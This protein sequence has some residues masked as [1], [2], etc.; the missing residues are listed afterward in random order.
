MSTKRMKMVLALMAVAMMLLGVTAAF[1]ED[2]T[3]GD[4]LTDAEEY[5]IGTDP[6]N[7]DSDGDGAGDWYEVAASF[8]DPTSASDNPGIVY[9]LPDPDSTPPDTTKPVKVYILS[10]SPERLRP[11]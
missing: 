4:G 8:T 3:D 6:T 11:L 10:G 5:A 1:A 9:P 7:P 2:D